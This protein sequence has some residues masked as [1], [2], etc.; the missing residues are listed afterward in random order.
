M[1][2]IIAKQDI[3][4]HNPDQS[5]AESLPAGAKTTRSPARTAKMIGTR[6][7]MMLAP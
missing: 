7:M 1:T 5:E 4:K 2:E 6:A 3:A